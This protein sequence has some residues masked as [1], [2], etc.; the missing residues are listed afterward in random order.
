MTLPAAHDSH[1][2]GG[3]A[4]HPIGASLLLA[5][6]TASDRAAAEESWHNHLA[7]VDASRILSD[8]ALFAVL[9][10]EGDFALLHESAERSEGV[11]RSIRRH[12]GAD[13]LLSIASYE[14]VFAAE[15]ARPLSESSRFLFL[16][17]A[18]VDPSLDH[19]AF[20]QWYD[21]T[22]VPDVGAVG[23]RRAQRFRLERAG[24][25]YLASYEIASPAVL[26]SP[27]LVQVRGFHHFTPSI[28]QLKRTV[29]ELVVG[30]GA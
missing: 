28:R 19:L 20:N 29:C 11:E 8:S 5:F 2:G 1:E 15:D 30:E 4:Q 27:E 16:A 6:V 13:R 23:L 12:F 25:E 17:R 24:D 18:S 14:R 26:E 21:T 3:R 7:D 22:H 9:E 10:G